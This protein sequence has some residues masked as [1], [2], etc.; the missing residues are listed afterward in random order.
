MESPMQNFPL[1]RPNAARPE[2]LLLFAA[3]APSSHNTQP[4]KFEVDERSLYL[5]ADRRHQLPVCD[6]DGRELHIS[7]GCALF[8]LRVAIAEA[9]C[10]SEVTLLPQTIEP[11]LLAEIVVS[12]DEQ[13]NDRELALLFPAI[14]PRRTYRRRF[15]ERSVPGGLLQRLRAAVSAEGAHLDLIEDEEARE[16]TADLVAQADE[17]QWADNDWRLE[18]ADWMHERR[19]GDG[20]VVPRFTETISHTIIRSFDMGNGIAAR[21]RE[22]ADGSP[23]LALLSSSEDSPQ[24]WLKTGMALEHALLLAQLEGVQ[25]SYLNQ[26]IQVPD[27]RPRLQ[28]LLGSSGRPQLLLRMGYTGEELPPTPRRLPE[29]FIHNRRRTLFG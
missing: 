20:L 24:A 9:G 4:W 8:N 23:V 25:A 13:R 3:L 28:S 19:R 29:D 14:F 26:P 15:E 7:C 11:D 2:T 17:R 21:N 18:L 22:L 1:P 5:Y 10:H 12:D 6:P 16:A 27:T